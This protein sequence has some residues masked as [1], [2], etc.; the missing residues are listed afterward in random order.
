MLKGWGDLKRFSTHT[1]AELKNKED[2][3]VHLIL[4]EETILSEFL[5]SKF[6]TNKVLKYRKPKD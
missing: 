6:F 4:L 1:K 3:R 2:K 5:G